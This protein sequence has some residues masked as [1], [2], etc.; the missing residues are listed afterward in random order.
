MSDN[1]QHGSPKKKGTLQFRSSGPMVLPDYTP[2]ELSRIRAVVSMPR[3]KIKYVALC[4][5]NDGNLLVFAQ[6]NDKL[7]VKAWRRCY[8]GDGREGYV[9]IH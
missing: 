6:A 1:E 8:P 3:S 4:K 7:S 2:A 5:C 9:N